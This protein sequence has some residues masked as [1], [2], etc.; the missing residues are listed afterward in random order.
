M[1][2]GPHIRLAYS[3]MGQTKDLYKKLI[4]YEHLGA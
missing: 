2:N 3:E 1:K 4:A